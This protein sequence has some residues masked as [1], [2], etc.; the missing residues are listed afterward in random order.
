[1]GAPFETETWRA[2]D[3]MPT[4]QVHMGF[5]Q[6]GEVPSH[7]NSVASLKQFEKPS[8]MSMPLDGLDS[9]P[10]P[11]LPAVSP[12]VSVL[13]HGAESA[14]AETKAQ[15]GTPQAY[16]APSITCWTAFQ[17]SDANQTVAAIENFI[18]AKGA[19]LTR[20]NY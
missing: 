12:G 19:K 17:S 2:V 8:L 20:R 11:P 3:L 14:K 5:D 9:L 13:V 16:C 7:L 1:M 10:L 6:V 18:N 4:H 15:T